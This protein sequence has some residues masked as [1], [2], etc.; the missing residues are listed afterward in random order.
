MQKKCSILTFFK[1]FALLIVCGNE[2]KCVILQRDCQDHK[3]NKYI[4]QGKKNNRI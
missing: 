2:Q 4:I 3:N 1:R